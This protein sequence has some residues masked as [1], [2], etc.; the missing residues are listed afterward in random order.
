[1]AKQMTEREDLIRDAVALVD[2]AE[3][4]GGSV[5]PAVIGFRR[6]GSASV[7]FGDE[8]VYQFT[9]DYQ[10]RRVYLLGILKAEN[11]RLIRW[12][13]TR[14]D[15]QVQMISRPLHPSDQAALLAEMRRMLSELHD[16]IGKKT[17]QA[18]RHVSQQG[19][20][21]VARA[22]EWLNNAPENFVVANCPASR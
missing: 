5:P 1:M 18:V 4:V 6:D 11:G 3:F 17:I 16:G 19:S 8:P 7:Y 2:R 14:T 21:A 15:H 10:L 9:S 12:E 13:K 22:V 20:D